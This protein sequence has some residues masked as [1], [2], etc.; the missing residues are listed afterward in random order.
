MGPPTNAASSPSADAESYVTGIST[1]TS[2]ER[3]PTPVSASGV[4]VAIASSFS[5]TSSQDIENI[6]I[7]S[8]SDTS[9]PTTS[10]ITSSFAN[11]SGGSKTYTASG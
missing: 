11:V 3:G 1:T 10:L 2:D 5:T 4:P 9:M 8:T 7:M 6:S